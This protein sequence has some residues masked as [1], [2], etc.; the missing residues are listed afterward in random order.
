MVSN[1]EHMPIPQTDE[2]RRV[3]HLIE[4]LADTAGHR[5]GLGRRRFLAGAGGVAAAFS[6]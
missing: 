1:G 4:G 2:Q 6:P 5:L 3:E